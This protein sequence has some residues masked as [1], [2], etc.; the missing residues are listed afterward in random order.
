MISGRRHVLEIARCL[1]VLIAHP[2]ATTLNRE[3]EI[4]APSNRATKL[5]RASM[6]SFTERVKEQSVL[7]KISLKDRMLG[8]DRQHGRFRQVEHGTDPGISRGQR[9]GGFQA[10]LG[11]QLW[12]WWLLRRAR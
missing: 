10:R 4:N 9:R 11:R 5:A 12:H 7:C 8:I 6:L 1:I 2:W 3:G